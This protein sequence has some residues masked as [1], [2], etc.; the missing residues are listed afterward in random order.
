MVKLLIKLSV[1][2]I[3]STDKYKSISKLLRTLVYLTKLSLELLS[4]PDDH[5]TQGFHT[6]RRVL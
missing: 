5:E 1:V 6:L 4:E 2:C 3:N